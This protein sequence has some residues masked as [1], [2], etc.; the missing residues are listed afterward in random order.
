MI[1][2]E[3]YFII[4]FNFLIIEGSGR[5]NVKGF[6]RQGWIPGRKT[7]REG[8]LKKLIIGFTKPKK[9]NFS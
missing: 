3:L 6:Y 7:S 8:K 4:Y 9:K 1:H 2:N 5:S